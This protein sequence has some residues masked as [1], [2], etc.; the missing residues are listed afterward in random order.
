MLD[1]WRPAMQI[2]SCA[3]SCVGRRD[4]NEDAVKVIPEIGLFV[5]ADGMGGDEG[6][7]V[8][9]HLVV[10]AVSNVVTTTASGRETAWPFPPDPALDPDVNLLRVAVRVAHAEVQRHKTGRLASMGST[11][12][13]LYL[14]GDRAVIGHLGD[15]RVYRLRKGVLSQ[16]TRDHS[17][18]EEMCSLGLVA[19]EDRPGFSHANVIT[20]AV[21]AAGDGVPDVSVHSVWPG[22]VFVLCTDGVTEGVSDERIAELAAL[23]D[24]RDACEAMICEAFESGAR[25]NI[26]AVVVRAIA[27]TKARVA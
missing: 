4:N 25:D 7:E 17:L 19:R 2:Q 15:S 16:L 9:S 27:T 14:R 6:G 23:P 13:A 5:V 18:F 8:A 11:I 22:D 26:T 10:D 3:R 20:R 24:V 12:A 21:G 1:E